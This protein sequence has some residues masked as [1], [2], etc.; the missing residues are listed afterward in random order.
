MLEQKVVIT[1]SGVFGTVTFILAEKNIFA[2]GEINFSYLLFK[3]TATCFPG[4]IYLKET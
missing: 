1:N 3:S 4:S 2:E